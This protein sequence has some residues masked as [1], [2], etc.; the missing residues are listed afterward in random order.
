MITTEIVRPSPPRYQP[1]LKGLGFFQFIAPIMSI[2]GA[3]NST[4]GGDIFAQ[5]AAARA[6]EEMV[7]RSMMIWGGAGVLGLVAFIYMNQ[8]KP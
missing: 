6:Q 7:K 2:I 1:S 8:R 4:S 5:Q 3:Q